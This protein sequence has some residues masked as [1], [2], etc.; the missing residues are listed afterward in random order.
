MSREVGPAMAAPL[1]ACASRLEWHYALEASARADARSIVVASEVGRLVPWGEEV[2]RFGRAADRVDAAG[3][4]EV[5][6]N[7]AC[8][9]AHAVRSGSRVTTHQN[10]TAIHMVMHTSTVSGP[11]SQRV[12][13]ERRSGLVVSEAEGAGPLA[14]EDEDNSA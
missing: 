9:G 14:L 3:G 7:A 5:V 1:A 12:R 2:L 6:E 11:C 13:V 10:R 8:E 4:V